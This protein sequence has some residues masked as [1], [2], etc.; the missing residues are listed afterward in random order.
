MDLSVVAVSLKNRRDRTRATGQG[1]VNNDVRSIDAAAILLNGGQNSTESRDIGVFGQAEFSWRERL[2]LQAGLRRDQSS[3]FGIDTKPFYSPKVG[4]SY[5]ISDEVYFQD[6]MESLPDGAVTQLR[7]RG[8]FGISGR[9]PGSGA[10]ST[11]DPSTNQVSLTEVAVGV[12]PGDTGNPLLRAEKSEEFEIGFD[13]ALADDRFGLGLV[14]FHKK[15]VDQILTLPVPP[16]LGAGGPDVN[17]GSILTDGY[18]LSGDVRLI[19]RPNVAWE[20]RGSYNTINNEVLDLGGIP[21]TTTRKE[22]YPLNGAWEYKILD[23]DPANNRVTVSDERVFVGN[24]ANYPGREASLS[25]TFTLWQSL[26][27]YLQGDYRGD[28][29]VFDG[30]TEF[31]DRAFGIGEVSEKGA[32]AYGVDAN[33]EPTEKAIIEYMKRYGP[34]YTETTGQEVSRRSVDGAYRQTVGTWKLREASV[35]YRIPSRLVQQYIRA[36]S[37]SFSLTMRNLYTWTNFLGLDP[38][39]DQFLSVPQDKRWTMKL[40]VAF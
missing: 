25:S 12:R 38:E 36:R 29:S 8:A 14:Y 27:F 19:T 31:R 21:E 17:V 39:S 7:L 13:A 30:T 33:G 23:V 4:L 18:E 9:Q 11:Y 40:T 35:S 26:T 15:G 5:V 10:R 28:H 32:A 2:F 22:G 37:A 24:G 1:L 20:V 6:L 34:F 3:T 16:S